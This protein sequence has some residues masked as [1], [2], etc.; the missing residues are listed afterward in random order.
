MFWRVLFLVLGSLMGLIFLLNLIFYGMDLKDPFFLPTA[1]SAIVILVCWLFFE[2]FKGP[3]KQIF[4]ILAL[5]SWIWALVVIAFVAYLISTSFP[6]QGPFESKVEM[7]EVAPQAELVYDEYLKINTAFK[8]QVV[9]QI[10][11]LLSQA[12]NSAELD[13]NTPENETLQTSVDEYLLFHQENQISIPTKFWSI[14]ADLPFF[15]NLEAAVKVRLLTIAAQNAAGQT[16][17]ACAQYENLWQIV[18][19]LNLGCSGIF[20]SA[21]VYRISEL[22]VSAFLEQPDLATSCPGEP[23]L[24]LIDDVI[25]GLDQN[26]KRSLAVHLAMSN[27]NLELY[28]EDN[29]TFGEMLDEV[30]NGNRFFGYSWIMK[31][32]AR[33]P[34]YDHQEWLMEVD[35]LFAENLLPECE[36]PYHQLD[37]LPEQD[38]NIRTTLEVLE[39]PAGFYMATLKP[40]FREYLKNKEGAKSLLT[41]YRFLFATAGQEEIGEPPIDNLTGQ[42][43]LLMHDSARTRIKSANTEIATVDLTLHNQVDSE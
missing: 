15:G 5:L 13:L 8:E 7:P 3:F 9:D 42:P 35:K 19:Q 20:G 38:S 28:R 31:R 33:K 27:K 2:K 34:L 41:A 36:K 22:L 14:D 23:I 18:K 10:D 32:K 26:L 40:H 43:F 4:R 24:A 12:K 21:A 1:L 17:L 39:R 37:P 11:D 25:S 16:D 30:H 6:K 29:E